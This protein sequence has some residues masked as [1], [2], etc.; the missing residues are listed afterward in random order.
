M[1]R[2]RGDAVVTTEFASGTSPQPRKR[3]ATMKCRLSIAGVALLAVFILASL[4]IW[5]RF[6]RTPSVDFLP[7]PDSLIALETSAG[8]KLLAQ[9]EF[10]ADYHPLAANFVAQSRPA[11]CGVA[12]SVIALNALRNPRPPLDQSTFF[13]VTARQVKDP[14]RVSLTGMSL[15]QLGDLLRA[16]GV[17][18]SVIFAS[19]TDIDSFRS[20][21][22]RNLMT[23]GDFVLVNYQ[24]AEL[25]QVEMGHISP[26]AA[27]HAET[28][29][30][31]ILDVA[32]YKY[33]PVWV[34]AKELWNAMSAPVGSSPR[35]RGFIVVREEAL[36]R[37]ASLSV[38]VPLLVRD[39]WIEIM[40]EV[41]P[42]SPETP[43]IE[44]SHGE[45]LFEPA[46][47]QRAEREEVA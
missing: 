24:R 31:L 22:Q 25:G 45:I 41:A 27:Y 16:H 12:S 3:V 42:G 28:D 2:G 19:D 43:P 8:E 40:R 38:K 26:L 35:T 44:S 9:S 21:A 10:I 5:N 37:S 14:L 1:N 33:P 30:F 15:R 18:A 6:F 47:S 20:I 29:R 39:H 4:L 46:R 32:A 17:E 36:T 34:S 23:D 7:L 13:S 11:Y